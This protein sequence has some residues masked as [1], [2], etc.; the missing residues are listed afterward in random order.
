MAP[1]ALIFPP[2]MPLE[3]C[4]SGTGVGLKST[5]LALPYCTF[6]PLNRLRSME[7]GPLLV[8]CEVP[9]FWISAI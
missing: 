3:S 7:R 4:C 9:T 8:F 6:P 2:L 5:Q 1:A